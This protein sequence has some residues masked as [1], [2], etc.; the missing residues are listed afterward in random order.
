MGQPQLDAAAI[1][2]A[3]IRIKTEGF[4]LARFLTPIAP[5][6]VGYTDEVTAHKVPDLEDK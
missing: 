6:D 1:R 2:A 4:S 5:C 3:S